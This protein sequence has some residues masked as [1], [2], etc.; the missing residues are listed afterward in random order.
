M[1]IEFL[2]AFP[3]NA[4]FSGRVCF[5]LWLLKSKEIHFSYVGKEKESSELLLKK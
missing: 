3:G 2:H 5:R 4:V 1:A